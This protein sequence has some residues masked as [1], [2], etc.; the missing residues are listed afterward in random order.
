MSFSILSVAEAKALL[1]T[2]QSR[3][4]S[5][6]LVKIVDIR[7]TA[8]FE[9]GHIESAVQIN[10]QTIGRYIAEADLSCPLLVY[11]YSGKMSQ[12]SAAYFSEQGF[13]EVYSLAGG[14]T[15]WSA[16]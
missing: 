1:S 10:E 8:S 3:C 14:Y 6:S 4:S 5:H 15:A 7:D 2:Q 16:D 11:C 9:A 12:I 13:D